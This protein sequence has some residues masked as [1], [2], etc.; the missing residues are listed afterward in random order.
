MKAAMC[1]FIPTSLHA[2]TP[3]LYLALMAV[4]LLLAGVYRHTR[5][6]NCMLGG[7]LL[8]LVVTGALLAFR[9]DAAPLVAFSGLFASSAFIVLAK[10]LTV[11]AA[12][13]VLLV[14]AGWLKEGQGQPF[15]FLVLTLLAVL[16]MLLMISANDML[17][18]YMA[19]E[20]SSL[21]LYVL[22]SF[23]RDDSKSSEAGLK[24][25][26]LGAL[27]SGMML[28]GMSLVYG[29]AGTTGFDALAKLLGAG[30]PISIGVVVGLVLI[31]VGFCFKLSAVPFHMWTPDVYEGAPTPVAAF[32]AT[33][34]KIAA[35]ALFTRVL[36]YPFGH[37]F[38]QWQQVVIFASVGSLFVGALAAIAQTNIKRL[39]A[40]S[41]IGHIGFML[42]ALAAGNA[43]GVQAMLIYLALYI[44]MSAGAFGCVLLMRRD[45]QYVENISDLA[46]LSQTKPWM[47]ALLALMMFSMTGIPPLA[48]FAGKM[49]VVIATVQ[50]GL[51]WLAIAGVV[52]GVIGGYYYLKVVKVMYFD[53]PAEAF[54]AEVPCSLKVALAISGF[55]TLFFFLLPTPLVIAAKT[56]AN[57]LINGSLTH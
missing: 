25:F 21:A 46:G 18:L 1:T 5:V 54:D 27:A 22:A 29:F 50:A 11:V 42:M 26:V 16:G 52:A 24:Y 53:T 4:V 44:F 34:P 30:A 57:A 47:A 32:F 6:N 51:A 33:A 28:F 14:S 56:A 10:L 20:L 39:L 12:I 38:A 7:T 31:M 48:G 45:G 19:L 17:S 13:M 9:L 40:Y 15:E 8:A 2:V 37:A 36:L 55:V 43:A 35:L 49:Y 41:S 3:E 23:K